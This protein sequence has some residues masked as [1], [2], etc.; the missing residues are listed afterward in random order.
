V[1]C[2]SILA[3]GNS[4]QAALDA[5]SAG[6][7]IC[8]R[9]GTYVQEPRVSVPGNFVAPISLVR[10][11]GDPA[12]LIRPPGGRSGDHYALRVAANYFKTSG[13]V[14]E[15]SYA[16]NCSSAN[17]YFVGSVHDDELS[18]SEIRGSTGGSGV[19]TEPG[20]ARISILRNRVHD[21]VDLRN[22]NGWQA[23]GLYIEGSDHVV[24]NNLVYDQPEGWGIQAYPS[25]AGSRFSE[26]TLVDNALGGFVLSYEAMIVNNVVA[27]NGG[28][29]VTRSGT[30]QG[31][32]RIA[33]NVIFGNASGGVE[34]GFPSSCTISGNTAADP[35][36]VNQ[37]GNDFHLQAGSPAVD[38]ADLLFAYSPDADDL[39]RPIGGGFDIGAY[40]R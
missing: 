35:L 8:L 2:N 20:S 22:C 32:C 40:E 25:G 36:L 37:A 3:P 15:G 24:A 38:A 34:S 19:M 5:A 12:P 26:N 30:G 11:P 21:N 17:V 27:F 29:G 16:N 10:Y 18:D 4:I 28:F 33:T 23:H 13:L 9:S 39:L 1:I 31:A 14:F 7:T 6:Q